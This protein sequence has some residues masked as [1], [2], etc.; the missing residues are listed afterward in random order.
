[1]KIK[2][3]IMAGGKGSRL[4]PLSKQLFPKQFIAINDKY[5]LMQRT[6]ITN[7]S[8]GKPTVVTT[9]EYS[10]IAKE[11]I[12]ILDI[13]VDFIIEPT[14]KN[15]ALCSIISVIQAKKS[16]YDMIMLLPS[17]HYIDDKSEYLRTIDDALNYAAKFGICTIGVTP[18]F[19]STEYGYIKIKEKIAEG[20]YST[21]EFI[22]K[23]NIR[24]VQY[25]FN[26]CYH[27][28]F[29]NSGIYICNID[30]IIEQY[31]LWQITLL[32]FAY[33]AFYTAS[34][35]GDDIILSD[36]SYT[37]IK[38]ISFDCAIIENIS[39]MIMVIAQF[40]W[41]D[42]GNWLSLWHMQTKDVEGNYSK[43]D[44]ISL[45]TQNSY[46]ISD[47]KLT[48]VIGMN[49]AIIINTENALLVVNKSHVKKVKLLITHMMRTGRQEL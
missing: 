25:Y 45:S 12:R 11:Q 14:P 32:Q 20:I 23:P 17:D 33:N 40:K 47:N 16:G 1:M 36:L 9:Q 5:S 37:N 49:N 4:W 44:V 41:Y 43:G 10:L 19:P 31:R 48:A 35:K 24:R 7:S 21:Q 42:L 46:I 13:N 30:Y 2:P 38:P 18:N 6:L 8:F 29:W 3:I 27:R 15:T 39:Q 28:Y 22:E 34:T 26:H